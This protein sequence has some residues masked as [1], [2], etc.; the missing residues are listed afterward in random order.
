MFLAWLKYLRSK[1]NN[2]FMIEVTAAIGKLDQRDR[3]LLCRAFNLPASDDGLLTLSNM[4]RKQLA[5]Q[6]NQYYTRVSGNKWSVYEAF[7]KVIHVVRT[8]K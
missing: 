6:C 8:G 1:R 5:V 2:Q 7:R 4:K 3:D